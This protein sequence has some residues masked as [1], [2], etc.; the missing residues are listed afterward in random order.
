LSE[1][2]AYYEEKYDRKFVEDLKTIVETPLLEVMKRIIAIKLKDQPKPKTPSAA[3]SAVQNGSKPVSSNLQIV[4]GSLKNSA[5]GL[6]SDAAG[7]NNKFK[8]FVRI[9]L[10]MKIRA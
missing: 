3:Y 1:I 2:I 5:T 10:Q 7:Q 9:F 6:D 8:F 4:N